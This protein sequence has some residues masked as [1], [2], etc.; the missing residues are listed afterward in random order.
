[1]TEGVNAGNVGPIPSLSAADYFV[2]GHGDVTYSLS[3]LAGYST[4]KVTR[5]EDGHSLIIALRNAND[6]DPA[7]PTG[8]GHDDYLVDSAPDDPNVGST[9]AMTSSTAFT[10]TAKDARGVTAKKAVAIVRNA[11]PTVATER[12]DWNAGP[13]GTQAAK[14]N[15]SFLGASEKTDL[16]MR[17][18][19]TFNVCTENV[20]VEDV[21]STAPEDHFRDHQ[22]AELMITV[23][24]VPAGISVTPKGKTLEITGMTSTW[25]LKGGPAG[26][27]PTDEPYM[28]YVVATDKQGL[29]AKREISVSVDAAPTVSIQISNRTLKQSDAA[30]V[31]VNDASKHFT[32]DKGA[33]MEIDDMGGVVTV[34]ADST[35]ASVSFTGDAITVTS[36]NPGTVMIKVTAS[37]SDSDAGLGQ[38]VSQ[39]FM[40]TVTAD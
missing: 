15:D 5:G 26:D 31:L 9:P 6:L 7:Q 16:T 2:G 4:F 11:P 36:K 20:V 14:V 18:K 22:E 28:F 8:T 3:G 17:C 13:I 32:D 33:D 29:S 35:V 30:T 40:V 39:T 34:P 25:N 27:T 24:G 12:T 19:T 37:E 1:V 21:E 10:I 38:F 23:E